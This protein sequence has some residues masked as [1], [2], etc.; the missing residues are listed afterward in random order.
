MSALR[1]A[2]LG[3]VVAGAAAFGLSFWTFAA[4]VR[5]ATPPD[6]PP[7]ADA[8]VS[9]T[10][11][12]T[13]RLVVGMRLL[14]EG[15]GR[16]LLV[17]GVNPEVKEEELVTILEAPEPLFDCCVDVGRYAEDTLGNAAETAA[18]AKR[19]GFDEIIVVTA[20]YHMPRSMAELRLAMPE[21][22]LISYP[23]R[24]LTAD[25]GSWQ[26]GIGA[27][28]RLAGEYVKL[29]VIKAREKLLSLDEPDVTPPTA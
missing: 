6:P 9:L 5:A 23:V 22:R 10:G 7:E 12:G 25:P 8:I 13:E 4:S 24:S 1:G 11:G 2:F 21:A 27:A 17:T 19:N 14:T 18:W 29:L 3:F 20:D 16:R 26:S 15:R 28:S